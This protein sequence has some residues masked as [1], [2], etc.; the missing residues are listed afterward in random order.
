[1]KIFDVTPDFATEDIKNTKKFSLVKANE[2]LG[3]LELHEGVEKWIVIDDLDLHNELIFQHQ[4]KTNQTVG[5]TK[6][7]IEKA[8]KMLLA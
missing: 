1:M 3:W 5:L 6:Q 8:E 2:I 7:D 4:I